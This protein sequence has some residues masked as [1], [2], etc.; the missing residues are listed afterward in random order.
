[1]KKNRLGIYLPIYIIFAVAAITLRSIACLIHLDYNLG[2][3]NES[4]LISSASIAVAVGC[5]FLLSYAAFGS[6]QKLRASFTTAYTYIPSGIVGVSLL[7]LAIELMRFTAADVAIASSVAL[8]CAVFALLSIGHFF[9]NAFVPARESTR[10]SYYGLA[11]VAFLAFYAAYLYFNGKTAINAPNKIVD[12]MAFLS[13][14]I[15]FLYEIRISLGRARWR[16]YICF[17]F[18]ASLLL[19]YFSKYSSSLILTLSALSSAKL[20]TFSIASEGLS[21]CKSSMSRIL[22]VTKR[23]SAKV[24]RFSA[25]V[26]EIISPRTK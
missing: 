12:Q 8:L 25:S 19:A 11:T 18:L 1:M 21:F 5:V 9:L 2:V 20:L 17:G 6:T 13:S 24:N 16:G 22:S 26:S 7:F 23:K 15:F 3:F 14:A 4:S 10:R